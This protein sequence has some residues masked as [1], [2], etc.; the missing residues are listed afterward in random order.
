MNFNVIEHFTKGGKFGFVFEI[1]T[2]QKVEHF[3]IALE[4]PL[5]STGA[6]FQTWNLEYFGFYYEYVVFH[7]K[8]FK[9]LADNQQKHVIVMEGQNIK[10]VPKFHL[11]DKIIK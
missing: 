11:F 7:S 6:N 2:P 4:Y 8:H 1:T 9:P 3:S 5:G 10:D